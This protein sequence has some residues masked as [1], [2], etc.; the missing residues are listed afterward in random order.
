MDPLKLSTLQ[1]MD[2]IKEY[3]LKY[4]DSEGEM[5]THDVQFS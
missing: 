5:I 3:L 4:N 2:L 1:K